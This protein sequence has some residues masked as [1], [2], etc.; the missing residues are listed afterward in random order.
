M[1]SAWVE[2]AVDGWMDGLGDNGMDFLSRIST[3][4]CIRLLI[5]FGPECIIKAYSSVTHFTWLS[6]L[7]LV[8]IKCC[9]PLSSLSVKWKGG[10]G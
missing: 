1:S 8:Q 7:I 2:S 4:P 5:Q 10:P 3:F 9:N 6:F